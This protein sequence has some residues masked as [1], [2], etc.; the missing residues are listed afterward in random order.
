VLV[1]HIASVADEA[2]HYYTRNK[3]AIVGCAIT[4]PGAVDDAHQKILRAS[5]YGLL[6]PAPIAESV[7]ESIH[8]PTFVFNDAEC[9]A[10]YEHR[11]LDPHPKIHLVIIAGY[12]IG[13]ALL[14]DDKFYRGAGH[15]GHLGRAP[16]TAFWAG[17]STNDLSY[18]LEAFSSRIAI[19]KA[20]RRVFKVDMAVLEDIEDEDKR[21]RLKRC[22]ERILAYP[23]ALDVALSDI[24]ELVDFGDPT[25]QRVVDEAARFLGIAVASA[26]LHINPFVITCSGELFDELPGYWEGVRHYSRQYSWPNAYEVVKLRRGECG[27]SAQYIG[28]GLLANDLI[29]Q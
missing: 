18:S 17:G 15:A 19:A 12:G 23:H 2:Y 6:S 1:N 11:G 20:L 13:S 29:N 10:T 22:R 27:R 5:R 24:R 7:T 8:I 21:D 26:I 9:I 28:C 14:I 3:K 25:V 4:A 16:V